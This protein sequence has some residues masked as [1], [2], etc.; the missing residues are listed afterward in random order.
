[1]QPLRS[2]ALCS[3]TSRAAVLLLAIAGCAAAEVR[4][5]ARVAVEVSAGAGAA[6]TTT[7][8]ATATAMTTAPAAT[9]APPPPGRAP[10]APTIPGVSVSPIDVRDFGADGTGARSDA[11][12]INRAIRAAEA[13]G[14]L[15]V[16]LPPGLYVVR[17]E[18]GQGILDA[19]I[20]PEVD[21][22]TLFGAPDG[23]S[24]ILLEADGSAIMVNKGDTSPPRPVRDLTVRDLTIEA[25]SGFGRSNAAIVQF[26]HSPGVHAA[27]LRIHADARAQH[28]RGIKQP[29]LATSQGT[30]GLLERVLIDGASKTGIYIASGTHHLTV[31][32]CETRN[33]WNAAPVN[34]PPPGIGITDAHDI[35]LINHRAHHNRGD[36]L[37]IATNGAPPIRV[38]GLPP[39]SYGS[40]Y[41][42]AQAYG[43]ATRIQVIGGSFSDNGETGGS[44]ITVASAYPEVPKDIVLSGVT[45]LNNQGPGIVVEAGAALEIE[46]AV[47]GGNGAHGILV[48]DVVL[49]GQDPARS[50]T[51]GVRILDAHIYDNGRRVNVD[52]GGLEVRGRAE[53][54]GLIGGRIESSDPGSRQR[55]GISL[56][57]EGGRSCRGFFTQGAP[58]ISLPI[59]FGSPGAGGRLG[60]LLVPA[61]AS[62]HCG[63]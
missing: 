42:L 10:D 4:T 29:G 55:V 5:G 9:L 49:P 31:R 22:L 50:R 12:A 7:A 32:D 63:P 35:T 46:G 44:G 59:P 13:S 21:G 1:M 18:P 52:V 6:T 45:T 39:D 60:P 19:S 33:M 56:V 53:R 43:P 51:S 8:T 47:V 40:Y 14:N 16:Y 24:R 28:E 2:P 48:R 34:G 54:V 58:R 3:S 30:S 17:Q 61:A 27:D 20:R 38:P 62:F 37:L 15:F 25:R 23:S 57:E 41:P 11:P 36:G 26:N